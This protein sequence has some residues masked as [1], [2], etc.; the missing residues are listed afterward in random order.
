M[1]KVIRNKLTDFV[2][3]K[4][5]DKRKISQFTVSLD[6]PIGNDEGAPLLI[7]KVDEESI[8]DKPVN[9][10]LEI[11][12]KIDLS[13]ALQKLTP[14][15]KKLCHL[16]GESELTTKQLSEY[17]KTPRSTVYDEIRRIRKIFMKENLEDYL[18]M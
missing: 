14:K 17:L 12:L 10:F 9:S 16:L 15:Q 5:A 18:K 6:Q 2:R 7:E 13:K 11:Q 3:E 8:S 4:E 1:G